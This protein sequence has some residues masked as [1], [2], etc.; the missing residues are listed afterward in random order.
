VR[1]PRSGLFSLFP[2]N[3]AF[4]GVIVSHRPQF[5]PFLS[6]LHADSGSCND[7]LEV[8]IRRNQPPVKLQRGPKSYSYGPFVR[9]LELCR[10]IAGENEPMDDTDPSSGVGKDRA[11]VDGVDGE[12]MTIDDGGLEAYL[13]SCGN[14]SCDEDDVAEDGDGDDVGAGGDDFGDSL[15]CAP[16]NSN[17]ARTGRS[18]LTSMMGDIHAIDAL[19][20]ILQ[21]VRTGLLS[22]SLAKLL[23]REG[24]SDNGTDEEDGNNG[25]GIIHFTVEDRYCSILIRSE[26]QTVNF[27]LA[28]A[29]EVR[30]RL[31]ER[32]PGGSE[33]RTVIG[34]VEME[35]DMCAGEEALSDQITATANTFM[36]IR[37]P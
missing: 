26:I 24:R 19:S 22:N 5:P 29:S 3:E 36:S 17:V 27:Y 9:A 12:L 7:I 14:S 30:R 16:I 6:S 11:K 35:D 2:R 20:K 1:A 4:F 33:G 15:Y 37:Y 25:T 31:V 21:N 34:K 18:A 23:H 13:D 32:L 8:E 10:D 28:L